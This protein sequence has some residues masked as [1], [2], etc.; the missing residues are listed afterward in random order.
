M[1]METT[2]PGREHAVGVLRRE[3]DQTL[4][5]HGGLVLVTGEAGIGKSTLV[6]DALAWAR[7]ENALVATG[8]C[9]EHGGAPGYW[10]WTQVLRAVERSAPATCLGDPPDPMLCRLLGDDD[11]PVPARDGHAEFQLADAVTSVLV[12]ASQYRPVVVAL[13]DLHWAD[14]ASLR[15]LEFA[16]AHTWYEQVLVIGT[17]RDDEV[18]AGDHP[19]QAPLSTLATKATHVALSGLDEAA[20][21]ELYVSVTGH[22]PEDALVAEVR[23]RT[24]GNPFFVEQ[25]ARV[26]GPGDSLGVAAAGLRATLERRLSLLP[27][28][29]R[30]VLALASVLGTDFPIGLLVA[31]DGRPREELREWLGIAGRARLLYEPEPD[32]LAFSH[33]L[34]REALYDALDD[35]EA[36]RLHA[37]VVAA[38][39][40]APHLA[41]GAALAELAHHACRAYPEIAHDRALG[42]VLAAAR[43]AA[44]RLAFDE[45]IA[46]YVLALD[47]EADPGCPALAVEPSTRGKRAQ[48][49][50]ELAETRQHA[51][52]L[53]GAR[54]AYLDV[55]ATARELGDPRLLGQAALGIHELGS[56]EDDWLGDL[57]LLEE[58]REHLEDGVVTDPLA[59]RLMSAVSRVRH[60]WSASVADNRELAARALELARDAGDDHTL[61]FALLARHDAIWTPGT[62]DERLAL[63]DE[64]RVVAHRRDDTDLDLQGSLLRMTALL[65]RG[66]PRG[67]RE[68]E[69]FV[70]ATDRSGLPRWRFVAQSRQATLAT[71]Q[72]RFDE[73]EAHLEA[74]RELGGHLGEVDTVHLWQAQRFELELLRGRFDEAAA[75]LD[76]LESPHGLSAF[77]AAKLA[78]NRG[79]ATAALG[80]LEAATLEA[81]S[82][83]GE[84]GTA[85]LRL[86]AQLAAASGESERCEQARA[87]LAS[88]IGDWGMQGAAAAIDGP[89]RLWAAVIDT[90]QQGFDEAVEGF[91]AAARAAERLGAR[92]WIAEA[93]L[94]EAETRLRRGGADDAEMAARLLASVVEEADDLGMAHVISRADVVRAS[95]GTVSSTDAPSPRESSDRRTGQFRF[96]G[97]VWTLGFAGVTVHM[98]DAKGLH[99]LQTLVR[100]AGSQ[101]Q[102]VQLANPEGGAEVEAS[103]RLGGDAMLDEQAKVA[104][105]DRLTELDEAIDQATTAHDDRRAAQL[106]AE[107]QTL[108]DELRRATGLGGRTRRLGDEAERARKTVTARIRDV[109]RRLDHRHPPLAEHLRASVSTGASCRYDPTEGVAWTF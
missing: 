50:L 40:Q 93:W 29:V 5:S 100:H 85:G 12:R 28:E 13:E 27:D 61:G 36:R 11:T 71:L 77:D 57:A 53:A 62:A 102:A 107:R 72:G 87:A 103:R 47:K 83:P 41:R 44:C 106:D 95:L 90:A 14:P 33:E 17:Y 76:T 24:G 101:I 22:V 37:E 23:R 18:E 25:T 60:H 52:D 105:R 92:P 94:G 58:A 84:F 31:V 80:H 35:K 45:A 81:A 75:V 49:T 39:E 20:V 34:V 64:M 54:R 88:V 55:V 59:V 86:M 9:W 82:L 43:E 21:G 98:G 79:D 51:G 97:Q 96:D 104:F 99:D 65:E 16:A 15:L 10:P 56:S 32:R 70:A 7:Q 42:H 89:L 74:A 19:A 63:A 67:L 1:A 30:N 6:T 69:A 73:A 91:A 108:L 4:A 66:D 38:I 109:L 78:V 46:H 68:H 8:A 3:L 2:L 26:S 48:V